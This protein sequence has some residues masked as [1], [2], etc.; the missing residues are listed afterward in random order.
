[1]LVLCTRFTGTELVKAGKSWSFNSKLLHGKS[2]SILLALTVE[3]PTWGAYST[4]IA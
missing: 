2:L 1:M 4:K 3:Q